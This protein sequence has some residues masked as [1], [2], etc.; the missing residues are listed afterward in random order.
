VAEGQSRLWMRVSWGNK[1]IAIQEG[2]HMECWAL[3][4]QSCRG[5]YLVMF[6]KGFRVEVH[7]YTLDQ[8]N[9]CLG[10]SLHLHLL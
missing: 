5:H 10:L 2:G 1:D 7:M 8:H 9:H 6:G 4:L 3:T